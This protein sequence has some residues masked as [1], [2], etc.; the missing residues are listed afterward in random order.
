MKIKFIFSLIVMTCAVPA[1]A[2]FVTVSKVYEINTNS[3]TIPSSQ[4]SPIRFNECDGCELTVAR[5]TPNTRYKVNGKKVLFDGFRDATLAAKQSEEA[6][7]LLKHH[8][9]S[10]TVV[11]VSI[12]L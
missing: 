11:S 4:N 1:L 7:V 8:L 2:D 6:A 5:L 12:I 10:G 3:L 9:E